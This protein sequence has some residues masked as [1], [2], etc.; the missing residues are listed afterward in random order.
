MGKN[1]QKAEKTTNPAGEDQKLENK[2]NM[3]AG[4]NKKSGQSSK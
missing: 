4:A 2:R 1:K 3:P